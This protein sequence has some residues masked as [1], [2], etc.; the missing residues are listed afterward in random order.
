MLTQFETDA[1]R[2]ELNYEL[3]ARNH[4]ALRQYNEKRNLSNAE[5][6]GLRADYQAEKRLL[7]QSLDN[8]LKE[9]LELKAR[10][11]ECFAPEMQDSYL[12]E[13]SLHRDLQDA[14]A[15]F[16]NKRYA[17]AARKEAERMAYEELCMLNKKWYAE[18]LRQMLTEAE[19]A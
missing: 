13:R 16:D 7:E 5:L 19:A 12:R 9:R 8:L 2:H 4:E 17:L 3:Q 6:N 1:R 10:G 11:L 15:T 14:R 18:Q